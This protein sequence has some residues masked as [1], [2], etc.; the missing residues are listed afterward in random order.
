MQSV[1]DY[2]TDPVDSLLYFLHIGFELSAVGIDVEELPAV[3]GVSCTGSS[4]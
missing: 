1:L 4:Q 3:C 2:S